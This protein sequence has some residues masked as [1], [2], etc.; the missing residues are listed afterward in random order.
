M[1]NGIL[2][3]LSGL[4]ILACIVYILIKILPKW[5]RKK[6]PVQVT[7][8]FVRKETLKDGK[9]VYLE[10]EILN[11][12]KEDVFV[13]EIQQRH[14]LG[15]RNTFVLQN[16]FGHTKISFWELREQF[17]KPFSVQAGA[18]EV[19]HYRFQ[20]TP[21][22]RTR[23]LFLQYKVLTKSHKAYTTNKMYFTPSDLE[24]E[25]FKP[26]PYRKR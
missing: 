7:I 5:R 8:N 4:L 23:K 9:Y 13:T 12:K 3:F 26:A 11:L 18:K 10:L 25:P 6:S 19:R 20:L 22:L 15:P 2:L 14:L 16:D 21:E 17:A 1:T 24:E